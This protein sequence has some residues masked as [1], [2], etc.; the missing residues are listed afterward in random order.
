[1]KANIVRAKQEHL[2]QIHELNKLLYLPELQEIKPFIWSE[3]AW[4]ESFIE[5]FFVAE[6][7]GVIVGALSLD[8]GHDSETIEL[9]SIVVSEEYQGKGIGKQLIAYAKNTARMLGAKKLELRTFTAYKKM[10][11][12]KSQGFINKAVI[13][14]QTE[15]YGNKF[16]Y[17]SMVADL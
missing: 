14:Y 12:Y 1:M 9:V 3:V 7:D 15:K 4:A 10:E 16:P 5:K 2:K 6:V 13:Y 11:F 8:K 17:H